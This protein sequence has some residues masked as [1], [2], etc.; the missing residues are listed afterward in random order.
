MLDGPQALAS[1]GAALRVCE[2]QSVA[3]GKTPDVRPSVPNP[4]A[5]FICSSLDLFNAFR[6]HGI[7]ISP[8]LITGGVLEV[9]PAHIWTI[10]SGTRLLP[11]KAT[12]AGR[13]A[14]KQILEALGVSGLPGVPT[15]DQ[16][17]AC[18]AAVLAAVAD[19]QVPGLDAVQ[20][21]APLSLDSEGAMREGP[22]VIAQLAPFVVDRIARAVHNFISYELTPH[23][24]AQSASGPP[25]THADDLLMRFIS[26]ATNGAPEVCTYGWAYRALIA[27]D[28][29]RFFQ[30][31]ARQSNRS[32][33]SDATA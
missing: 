13:I 10:L 15:H 27:A 29:D 3:V 14:R 7:A 18:V 33:L 9:Y 22:M 11:R 12:E 4:F 5:G 31:G 24:V 28:L 2:R 32:G 16:N 21:G 8:S 25:A 19:N 20:L 30:A 17:D 23:S 26:Q 6:G 1:K